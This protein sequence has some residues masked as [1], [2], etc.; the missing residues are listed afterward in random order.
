MEHTTRVLNFE[1]LITLRTLVTYWVRVAADA[2]RG[3]CRLLGRNVAGGAHPHVA[4]RQQRAR[5]LADARLGARVQG[6]EGPVPQV[7]QEAVRALPIPLVFVEALPWGGASEF[8]NNVMRNAWFRSAGNGWAQPAEWQR[9]LTMRM[10]VRKADKWFCTP[11]VMQELETCIK[12]CGA[13]FC[14]LGVPL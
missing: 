2:V 13:D 1:S 11:A 10:H 6:P 3:A 5:R 8:A 12:L 4:R 14:E 9:K 7:E